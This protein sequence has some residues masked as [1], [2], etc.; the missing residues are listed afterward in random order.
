MK[1]LLQTQSHV[2]VVDARPAD[3]R[4]L[5]RLAGE[6]GWH[7]HFLT[8]ARAAVRFAR[9][10]GVDLWIIGIR[11]PDMSGFELFEMLREHLLGT[12]VFIVA[13]QYDPEEERR[14]CGCGAT[15]YLCKNTTGVIQGDALLELLVGQRQGAAASA[16]A[17][18]EAR[19]TSAF[20]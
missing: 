15:L 5:P 2:V 12:P 17:A 19:H 18:Q 20:P 11:L 6:H 14:V 3:Y 8:S 16:D 7:V 4:N 9:S 10:G 13:V 1:Q